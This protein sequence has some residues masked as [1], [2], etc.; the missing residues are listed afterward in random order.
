MQNISNHPNENL[1]GVF[2]EY[3]YNNVLV[4]FIDGYIFSTLS[5]TL[6]LS[7]DQYIKASG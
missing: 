6:S 1:A 5:F 3:R 2:I 4:C 7:L